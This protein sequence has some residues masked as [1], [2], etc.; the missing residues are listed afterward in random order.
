MD[1]AKE[2]LLK[3]LK[4]E[5][6]KEIFEKKVKKTSEKAQK[7]GASPKSNSKED[8]KIWLKH[9]R[10]LIRCETKS[11]KSIE[12]TLQSREILPR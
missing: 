8:L 5:P 7:Q 9:Q 4:P 3:R 1:V 2:L 6:E 11:L 12:E 10:K